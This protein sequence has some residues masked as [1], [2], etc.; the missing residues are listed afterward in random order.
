MIVKD[1]ADVITRCLDSV[2][3]LVDYVFVEDTGSTDGTQ[4]IIREWLD[5]AHIAGQVIDEPWQSFPYNRTHALTQ[6]RQVPGLD[7]ALVVDADDTIQYTGKPEDIKRNLTADSYTIDIFDRGHVYYRVQICSLRKRFEY[8]G[9]VHEVMWPLEKV[10][11]EH[12]PTI[13]IAMIG[14]GARSRDPN[15]FRKDV[16][17]FEKELAEGCD[18]GFRGRYLFYLAQSYACIGERQKAID[19]YERR[20]AL[21]G[22]ADETYVALLRIAELKRQLDHPFAEIMQRLD[23]ASK[24]VPVRGEALL[25][26]AEL[27]RTQGFN[28]E[29]YELAQRGII[30]QQPHGLFV[31]AATYQWMLL[32]EFAIAAFSARRYV[33]SLLACESIL[34]TSGLP[35]DQRKRIA[36]N[37]AQAREKCASS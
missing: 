29:A 10:T 32:D 2:R 8:R 18:E 21:G 33:E 4:D 6:L 16:A 35:P 27:C 15:S 11:T 5:E 17:A 12:L 9:I 28:G 7:Y 22:W 23:Q 1:E 34:K 19:T 24:M 25:A 20:V 37:A 14:G 3:E 13:V 26:A 31:H 30:L 36:H